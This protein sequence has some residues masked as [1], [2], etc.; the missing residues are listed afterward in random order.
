MREATSTVDTL[1]DSL[2]LLSSDI[3]TSTT[4]FAISP[5]GVREVNVS[6]NWNVDTTW[7]PT[8]I[9]TSG[10]SVYIAAGKT[11]TIAGSDSVFVGGIN[12]GG[13]LTFASNGALTVSRMWNNTGGTIN[14]GSG[15]IYFSGSPLL[16]N[17]T[18]HLRSVVINTGKTLTMLSGSSLGISQSLTING[19]LDALTYTPN[20]ILYNGLTSQTITPA[21][22]HRLVVSNGNTKSLSSSVTV[23]DSLRIDTLTTLSDNAQSFTVKGIVQNKGTFSGTGTLIS[24]GTVTLTGSGTYSL[25]SV[26]ILSTMNLTSGNIALTLNGDLSN[27]GTSFS[28]TGTVTFAGTNRTITGSNI[29][30]KKLKITGSINSSASITLTD[31]FSITGSFVS[32][33][34]TDFGG[35]TVLT[36]SATLFS[37]TI[38]NTGNSNTD[39]LILAP[40]SLLEIRQSLSNSSGNGRLTTDQN[41][42]NT[43]W[44]S[45][46]SSSIVGIT[47]HHLRLTGGGTKF[48]A[49]NITINGNFS[50]DSSSTF[51]GQTFTTVF[52]GTSNTLSST[53]TGSFQFN[54]LTI[55]SGKSLNAGTLSFSVRGDW[56]NNGTFTSSGTGTV[57]LN[58]TTQQ[59]SRSLFQNMIL[60]GSGVKTVTGNMI[61]NGN[62]TVNSGA[63]VTFSTTTIDTVKGN[64]TNNGSFIPTNSTFV[65]NGT[66]PQTIGGSAFAFNKLII[67]K[68]DSIILGASGNV[69]DTLRLI[70]GKIRTNNNILT[71]GS[72]GTLIESGNN[73][74]SGILRTTRNVF[75]GT[76]GNTFGNLGL[77]IVAVGNAPG[78]TQVTRYTDTTLNG[79]GIFSNNKS[80]RRFFDIVPVTNTN[81][82]ATVEFYYNANEIFLPNEESKLRLWNTSDVGT[83]WNIIPGSVVNQS[84]D[85]ITVNGVNSLNRLTASS[86]TLQPKTAIVRMWRDTD[87]IDSTVNDWVPTFWG[88]EARRGSLIGSRVGFTA[89]D[90]IL[91]VDTLS[92]TTYYAATFDSSRWTRKAYRLDGTLVKSTAN[93]VQFG[94]SNTN[95]RTVEFSAFHPS[96]LT[97]R[98]VKDGDGDFSTRD[99]T[100]Q[101]PW[102]FTLYNGSVQLLQRK[103]QTNVYQLIDSLLE[104]YAFTAESRDSLGWIPLGYFLDSAGISSAVLSGSR[105]ARRTISTFNGQHYTITFVGYAANAVIIRKFQDSDGEFSTSNDRGTK[106]WNLKIYRQR[107]GLSDT[108]V[109]EV[110]NARELTVTN[111]PDGNYIATEADSASWRPIGH[112]LRGVPVTDTS[113]SVSFSISGGDTTRFDF[114][115]VQYNTIVVKYQVD[116]DNNFYNDQFQ[117]SYPWHLRVHKNSPSG[118]LL[119]SISG[120][121]PADTILAV[122]NLLDGI[123]YAVAV[124]SSGWRR[125]GNIYS[126]RSP[127]KDTSSNVTELRVDLIGGG[128][129]AVVTFVGSNA[130]SASFRTLKQLSDGVRGKALKLK[131][132]KGKPLPVHTDAN[133]RDTAFEK[134]FPKKSKKLM[135][136]GME[137]TNKDS[138]KK[139]GWILFKKA[140][141][142]GKFLPQGTYRGGFDFIDL[143]NSKLFRKALKNPK[144][145]K[146][147]NK[148][149]AEL[150]ILKLNIMAS[151]GGVTPPGF[152]KL[153]FNEGGANIHQLNGLTVEQIGGTP[154]SGGGMLPGLLD[155]AL[156]YH[157]TFSSDF[158]YK[159]TDALTKINEAFWEAASTDDTITVIPL[160]LNGTKK[161]SEIDFLTTTTSK[162]NSHNNF[163]TTYQKPVTFELFQNYPNPFNAST[164]I[165]YY[166]ADDAVVTLKI[167]NILGQEVK[168]LVTNQFVEG[169]WNDVDFDASNLVSGV[170]FYRIFAAIA[171]D[172]G[173]ATKEEYVQTKKLILLK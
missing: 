27:S 163:L 89:S 28:N 6:G 88:M 48:A 74:I 80:I 151:E 115:N 161:L 146:Y 101:I 165:E 108:L 9:P 93:N 73:K 11:V 95:V 34:S 121:D 169:G 52:N 164:T 19:T 86:L 124:D 5:I 13:T 25:G 104:D 138:A 49:G 26:Q 145:D 122:P 35:T 62:I 21:T 136:L 71:L 135:I 150:A 102:D 116:R 139:Y 159:A 148:I 37:S 129:T 46:T 167:Y 84:A 64:F 173:S 97:L 87:G 36:G 96:T 83:T 45:S 111:L 44:Y 29:Q 23:S 134:G 140:I 57:T 55:N 113:R 59:L 162:S 20:T 117:E 103:R 70:S 63:T 39:T 90:S 15:T 42:S 12:I 142:I 154:V 110:A 130:D 33:A 67:N 65:F 8:G 126:Q 106:P 170:Y 141:S 17:G 152:G 131:F 18:S 77:K 156:T 112:I 143:S 2:S 7:S 171:D 31:S 153:R 149:A 58:G 76:P 43:V 155:S 105:P 53:P 147:S 128:R 98:F 91:I 56:T 79:A 61:V 99:D 133:I 160:K 92:D 41:T 69:D 22:Y 66:S 120:T 78:S 114:V 1:R 109:G 82:N 168:T 123:Y 3:S 94:F 47:Y 81:L 68:T 158:F 38:K 107:E 4:I 119:G 172:E 166:L 24:G 144:V 127:E 75:S 16:L 50:V 125:L 14:N 32:S 30:F 51:D 132:K 85:F 54:N 137:Q 60:G 118:I 40:N 157:K 72:T 100:V 10:D